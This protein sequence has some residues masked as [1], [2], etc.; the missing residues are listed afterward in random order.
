MGPVL[1]TADEIPDPQALSVALRVN[2][3]VRQ[4]SHTS[5]MI[6][7]VDECIAVLSEGFTVRP[8]DVIA[9]GTPEGV[10]AALGK[11]LKIGDRMEAE[12]EQIGVLENRV[13]KP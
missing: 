10:G 9:T 11:F 8:G 1:V 13:A 3:E 7:P 2:G 5:K 4:S 12:V 6:F